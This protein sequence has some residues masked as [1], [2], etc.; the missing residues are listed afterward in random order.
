[1]AV[2]SRL[3]EQCNFA[4]LVFTACRSTVLYEVMFVNR[5]FEKFWQRLFI[6]V[7]S[8]NTTFPNRQPFHGK[9]RHAGAMAGSLITSG[10]RFGSVSLVSD[11]KTCG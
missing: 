9:E 10:V 1:M 7:V 2:G 11:S 4:H 5:K 8:A 3:N 6:L